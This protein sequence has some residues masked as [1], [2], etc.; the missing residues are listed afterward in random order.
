MGQSNFKKLQNKIAKKTNPR[1]GKPYGKQSAGRI[2]Y[3][4][5]KK[6]YGKK[7]MAKKAA[8]GRKKAKGK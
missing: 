8:A 2:T 6:K 7:G 3:S 5:G 4:I 1:T